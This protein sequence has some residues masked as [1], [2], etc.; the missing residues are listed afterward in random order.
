MYTCRPVCGLA[1]VLGKCCRRRRWVSQGEGQVPP[2]LCCVEFD[3]VVLP[4]GGIPAM[5]VLRATRPSHLD[6]WTLS[7]CEPSQMIIPAAASESSFYISDFELMRSKQRLTQGNFDMT[8]QL[9]GGSNLWP[10][11]YVRVCPASAKHVHP[12]NV[13]TDA[14]Q[15]KQNKY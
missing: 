12:A 1:H 14:S 11:S 13:D 7:L 5:W 15:L 8:Y 2:V 6:L 10:V 3:P 4:S 9:S